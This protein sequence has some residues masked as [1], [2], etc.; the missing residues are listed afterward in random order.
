MDG[1]TRILPAFQSISKNGK[2]IIELSAIFWI[3]LK[4]NIYVNMKLHM[5]HSIILFRLIFTFSYPKTKHLMIEY[6]S[7]MASPYDFTARYSFFKKNGAFQRSQPKG[8]MIF[9]TLLVWRYQK[10]IIGPKVTQ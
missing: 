6:W 7:E 10:K 1:P 2:R 4:K 9:L 3:L 5:W 8:Q